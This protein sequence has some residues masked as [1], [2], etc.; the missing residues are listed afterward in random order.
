MRK[1][2]INSRPFIL[3]LVSIFAALDSVV[4]L[5]PVTYAVGLYKFFSLGWVFS[6]FMGI[7]IGPI[8]GFTAATLG[9]LIRASIAPYKWT[10]GPFSPFLPAVSALQAGLL[11]QRRHKTWL[12]ILAFSLLLS[13][14]LTWLMLPTGRIVWPVALYYL[15]GLAMIPIVQVCLK[16]SGKWLIVALVLVAYVS[17][18]TQHAL[19]NILSVLLLNVPA[20]IFWTTL[21][22]PLVE[23]TAFALASGVLTLSIL[24][25]LQKANL[26]QYLKCD[27][28]K[29]EN[30]KQ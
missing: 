3:I 1:G 19:G 29:K 18:I 11:T 2:I 27:I 6:P 15:A 17:N 22:L 24:F 14:T 10:F 13:L 28:L 7:L 25:A 8:A 21:P 30:N 5:V 23:Q 12:P 4:R 26:L 16:F 9:S 20:E